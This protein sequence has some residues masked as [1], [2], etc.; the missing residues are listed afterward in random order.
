MNDSR[1]RRSCLGVG[2]LIAMLSMLCSC[3][4]GSGSESDHRLGYL[5]G[6]YYQN[7]QSGNGDPVAL[8]IEEE[9][10]DAM[11][12]AGTFFLDDGREWPVR[13]YLDPAPP[14]GPLTATDFGDVLILDFDAQIGRSVWAWVVVRAGGGRLDYGVEALGGGLAVPP[15]PNPG[16]PLVNSIAVELWQ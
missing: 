16:L 12:L 15:A 14:S 8:M 7:G 13:I 5:A 10:I 9:P 11:T 3:S 2:G 6:R 1:R 4:G